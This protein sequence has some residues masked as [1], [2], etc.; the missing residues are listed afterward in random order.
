V[1]IRTEAEE[2]EYGEMKVITGSENGLIKGIFLLRVVW[3]WFKRSMIID[4]I[5]CQTDDLIVCAQSLVSSRTKWFRLGAC[6]R[7]VVASI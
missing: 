6:K 7:K 1:S 5:D 2:K 4:R 3:T